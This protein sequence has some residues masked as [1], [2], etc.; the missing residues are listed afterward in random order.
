MNAPV[1][2]AVCLLVQILHDSVCRGHSR[3]LGGHP[4]IYGKPSR[5][6]IEHQ[7]LKIAYIMKRFDDLAKMFSAAFVAALLPATVS[8]QSCTWVSSTEGNTWQSTK[9]SLQSAA[10]QS[11]LWELNG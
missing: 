8:A 6:C 2:Q 1:V 5:I 4:S 10:Q 3:S 9:V 11:P 7:L